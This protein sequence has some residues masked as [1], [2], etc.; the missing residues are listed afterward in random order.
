MIPKKVHYIWLGGTPKSK[1]AEV[2]IN[3]WKR[4]LLDY[5]IIEWN[6]DNLNLE[7]MCKQNLFLKKCVSLKLWAF[8]SDY[9]RLHVLYR[10]GGIYLDT[11][12]EVLKSYDDLLFHK[13][14][15][16]YEG[17]Y[18]IGTATIGAEKNSPLIKALLDFY[19][20]EIWNVSFINN[21]IIFKHLLTQK[22]DLFD[23]CKLYPSDYFSPYTRGMQ[24][25]GIVETMNTYSIH[26]FTNN[27]NMSMRGYVF[28]HTKHI[29][30]PIKRILV[31]I[32][33]VL[34]YVKHKYLKL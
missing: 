13:I 2:C 18:Y 7:E 33:K 34:G 23:D 3:S 22:P 32:R 1:L 25:E 20:K 16:G 24:V 28:M 26:W 31:A 6:E 4:I 21:P 30:N 17:D 10:E 14:F 29:K 9:I 15:L 27:W 5:E 11:D 12:V 8:V 19:E